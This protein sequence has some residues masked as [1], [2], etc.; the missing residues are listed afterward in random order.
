MAPH[1]SILSWKILMDRGARQATVHGD[2]ESQ[3]RM[4][5]L[6]HTHEHTHASFI[7]VC[8]FASLTE[9]RNRFADLVMVFLSL[10]PT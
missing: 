4:S 1:S 8:S 5:K 10:G 3:T 7:L 6:S 2:T 9:G